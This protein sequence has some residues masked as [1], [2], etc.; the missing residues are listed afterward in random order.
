[1]TEILFNASLLFVNSKILRLL[2]KTS[3]L[4]GRI[5]N[6]KLEIA[7]DEEILVLSHRVSK[8]SACSYH[9]I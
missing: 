7:I 8:A 1:M 6:S 9:L 3:V 5:L 4:N 2:S